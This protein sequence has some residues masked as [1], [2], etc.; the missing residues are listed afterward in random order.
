MLKI[1]ITGI[2]SISTLLGGGESSQTDFYQLN[3]LEQLEVLS[4]NENYV[5]F[6]IATDNKN[7]R[8]FRHS[9]DSE[10]L[11]KN[12]QYEITENSE[13]FK[14]GKIYKITYVGDFIKKIEKV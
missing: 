5:S 9:E 14:T 10:N 3:K 13:N 4:N 11:P 2:I 7:I 1:A 6:G 12:E 8:I